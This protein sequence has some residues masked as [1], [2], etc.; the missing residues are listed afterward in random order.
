M[1]RASFASWYRQ[2][3]ALHNTNRGTYRCVI[4]KAK[5]SARGRNSE[6][7]LRTST[8]SMKQVCTRWR[9]PVGNRRVL[10][11]PAL[12]VH[13]HNAAA[14]ENTFLHW[15]RLE[16][17]AAEVIGLVGVHSACGRNNNSRTT[18]TSTFGPRPPRPCARRA[19]PRV[20]SDPAESWDLQG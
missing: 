19:L 3:C 2:A 6:L 13:T 1:V 20:P 5:V 16:A 4:L 14:T 18:T 7:G 8:A 11:I 9:R 10:C 17:C 12:A 15:D